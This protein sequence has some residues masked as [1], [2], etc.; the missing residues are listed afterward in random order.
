MR[1]PAR[2]LLAGL[3][4]SALLL[5]TAVPTA[6]GSARPMSRTVNGRYI[7]VCPLIGAD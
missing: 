5:T 2:R 3:F 1:M 6:G 4:A 7:D